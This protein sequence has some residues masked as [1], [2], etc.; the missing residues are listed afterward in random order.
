MDAVLFVKTEKM[1]GSSV[2]GLVKEEHNNTKNLKEFRQYK[3]KN[4]LPPHQLLV[5]DNSGRELVNSVGPLTEDSDLHLTCEVRGGEPR[6]TVSWF[7]NEKLVEASDY[8]EGN[9]LV[10]N[11]LTVPS[12]KRHHL[13]T[14]YK[15]QASNTKLMTPTEKTVR[16]EM[17]LKPL[18]VHLLNKRSSLIADQEYS[19]TCQSSG[20][21]P[22]AELTWLRENRKFRRGKVE[23]WSNESVVTSAVIFSPAPEDDGHIL[24]CQALNPSIP[25]API[26]D[27]ITLNV[28]YAPLVSLQLGTSLKP[29]Q[30]KEGDDVYFECNV[31]AN[32]RQHKINWFH[33]GEPVTQNMSTGVLFSTQSLVL[34]GV[35]RQN[36]GRYTCVASNTRGQT[37]SQPVNLRIQYAPV[38]SV[39][40]PLIVGA[41]LE[42]AVRVRCMVSADPADLTFLWQFNNSGESFPVAPARYATANETMS[43]LVYTPTSERDY[44]TLACWATNSIGRQA[45]PCT[46]Q[47]VPAT[48]PGPLHNCTLRSTVNTTGDWLEVECIAGFDGGLKQTFHL[49][50]LDSVTSKYCLNVSNNEGPF[51]RVELAAL[52]NG[53]PGTIQLVIY[54]VNQKGRSE[55]VVLE[56]IAIRDAEKRTE[57]VAGS[58]SLGAGSLAALLVGGFLS[59]A[60]ILLLVTI[61]ALRRRTY[62]MQHT[63][64]TPTKQIEIT[65]GDDQR[66]V[67]SYQLK[68]ETKQPDIL[69]RVTDEP[70]ERDIPPVTYS[71]PG[72][73]ATFM[74]P[75]SSPAEC[76]IPISPSLQTAPTHNGVLNSAQHILSNSIP[77]PESC[78]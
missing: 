78:V 64:P 22:Q 76:S 74:S 55:L 58:H 23:T 6:P 70:L 50:A 44:G 61:Y 11:K 13:N 77:G 60:A 75:C 36:G 15:C 28:V 59:V 7:V 43:E 16:L 68:P 62:R 67:V 31:R 65:Q 71:G 38:C 66:Y 3:H 51:F 9:N 47:V 4:R 53:H 37:S 72:V 18:E 69:H 45:D 12:L 63:S 5:F 20:S 19:L 46:F 54:A 8:T 49:E 29:H 42:E 39:S 40:E 10:I 26:E 33:N 56:D 48:K 1:S 27:S 41:S 24:K 30:I 57:W 34:Q 73:T 32:P 17:F 21:R 35:T 52:A 2:S 25:S 14:T